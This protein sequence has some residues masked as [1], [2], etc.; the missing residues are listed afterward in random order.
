MTHLPLFALSRTQSINKGVRSAFGRFMN[1][2]SGDAA[3][4]GENSVNGVSSMGVGGSNGDASGLEGGLPMRV[5]DELLDSMDHMD[6]HLSTHTQFLERVRKNEDNLTHAY[7]RLI[8]YKAFNVPSE[9]EKATGAIS[10]LK[11]TL[12]SMI[13][14]TSLVKSRLKSRVSELR[15]RLEVLRTLSNRKVPISNAVGGRV[16]GYL[17]NCTYSSVV[18]RET[19]DDLEF[20]EILSGARE[21]CKD[22]RSKLAAQ[23]SRR[24]RRVERAKA[25]GSW[26]ATSSPGGGK[27]KKKGPGKGSGDDANAD[28]VCELIEK[29]T[30][31]LGSWAR[32]LDGALAQLS[33][34][35]ERRAPA[36]PR[37]SG[38]GGGGDASQDLQRPKS[39][40]DAKS[41]AKS[42]DLNGTQALHELVQRLEEKITRLQAQ[43]KQA[44]RDQRADF[45]RQLAE[46]SE[47]L[48][49]TTN[50]TLTQHANTVAKHG[51]EVTILRSQLEAASSV[52]LDLEKQNVQ[53]RRELKAQA[54]AAAADKARTAAAH[55]AE[56]ER[57]QRR[58]KRAL[59]K[60]VSREARAAKTKVSRI[61][62]TVGAKD[63]EASRLRSQL[64]AS[65]E[66]E[67]QLQKRVEAVQKRSAKQ[68]SIERARHEAEIKAAHTEAQCAIDTQKAIAAELDRQILA[69]RSDADSVQCDLRLDLEAYQNAY[70]AALLDVRNLE[71]ANSVL[72]AA[73]DAARDRLTA[74]RR[75]R[76]AEESESDTKNVQA[77]LNRLRKD[78]DELFETKLKRLYDVAEARRRRNEERALEA[79]R[80]AEKR[81]KEEAD[82]AD[83][84]RREAKERDLE[85][86]G[87]R[88]AEEYRARMRLEEQ[89]RV[90]LG[91]SVDTRYGQGVVEDKRDGIVRV[92]LAFG[93]GYFSPP[94]VTVLAGGAGVGMDEETGVDGSGLK[95]SMKRFQ[96]IGRWFKSKA[97]EAKT[98]ISNARRDGGVRHE[99]VEAKVEFDPARPLGITCQ[100]RVVT[101]VKPAGQAAAGGVK[102]GWR[103]ARV[104][105]VT[106]EPQNVTSVIRQ[107]MVKT[108][109]SAQV[110]ERATYTVEFTYLRAVPVVAADITAAKPAAAGDTQ[111]AGTTTAAGIV[112]KWRAKLMSRTTPVP[113]PGEDSTTKNQESATVSAAAG[114]SGLMKKLRSRFSGYSIMK[115][116]GK[117]DQG[118]LLSYDEEPVES[119]G[120]GKGAPSPTPAGPQKANTA[121]DEAKAAPEE[122]KAS[123]EETM[124]RSSVKG[125][126]SAS[127]P[128]EEPERDESGEEKGMGGGPGQPEGKAPEHAPAK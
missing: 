114:G 79:K 76:A 20:Q 21:Q 35:A 116:F 120:V 108:R 103:I 124:S 37:G 62:K 38:G 3:A 30:K 64:N 26:L 13:N 128:V 16:A 96:S 19:H 24:R 12:C 60:A 4:S 8:K 2:V 43:H 27:N 100:G 110:D 48:T 9:G 29:A 49:Q 18:S 10:E 127:Q 44:M 69:F 40:Q 41:G 1:L 72:R 119:D 101:Q 70:E 50:D 97:L 14:S 65:R 39:A 109:A 107:T 111:G 5:P 126:K 105:G 45:D 92:R 47:G 34:V 51:A 117:K 52:Q 88:E 36:K 71:R 94:R 33:A 112:G 86:R 77:E 121:S 90:A 17:T 85:L 83:R 74:D 98:L 125:Q 46:V 80:L 67:A 82:N 15:S 63:A 115:S 25:S 89:N 118:P 59:E 11:A 122:G 28:I 95:R 104:G 61:E 78:R 66:R 56:M 42:G 54:D 58:N 113:A 73:V 22:T 68:L 102:P 99:E 55:K 87:R 53:L 23:L 57:A 31:I 81:A 6:R 7:E 106:V 91:A 75:S 93:T 123:S 84:I 32:L